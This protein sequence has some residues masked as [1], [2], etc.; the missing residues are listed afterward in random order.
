MT[1]ISRRVWLHD[2]GSAFGSAFG[3]RPLAWIDIARGSPPSS[4]LTA[5]APKI[6]E[7]TQDKSRQVSLKS[8]SS[9]TTR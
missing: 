7:A 4:L 8:L 5:D 3:T 6:V 1:Q 9:L 2:F